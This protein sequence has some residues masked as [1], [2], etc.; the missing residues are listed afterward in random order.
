MVQQLLKYGI[1]IA[2]IMFASCGSVHIENHT[3]YQNKNLKKFTT[4]K[5]YL[6]KS[7]GPKKKKYIDIQRRGT[8]NHPAVTKGARQRMKSESWL[9]KIG[10][11]EIDF[12]R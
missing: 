2:S 3:R 10:E 6:S 9:K 12:L 4:K 7:F 8:Y 5:R 1:L 11:G